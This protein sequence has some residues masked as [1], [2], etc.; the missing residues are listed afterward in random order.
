MVAP[1]VLE[2]LLSAYDAR[3]AWRLGLPAGDF[4][5]WIR[6]FQS[7]GGTS[8]PSESL[9]HDFVLKPI[10]TW[11][12]PILRNHD[13]IAGLGN[14][15]LIDFGKPAGHREVAPREFDVH[16]RWKPTREQKRKEEEEN[17]KKNKKNKKGRRRQSRKAEA[18]CVARFA[19]T[20]YWPYTK[21][22]HISTALQQ[23]SARYYVWAFGLTAD[24]CMEG[25]R[26]ERFPK[27]VDV[28][29]RWKPQRRRDEDRAV[30]QKQLE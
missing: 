29:A 28:H 14:I 15:Y 2:Q 5:F 23:S 10:E 24:R 20:A 27:E 8:K 12:F 22:V 3:E 26:G 6:G 21:L 30:D 7:H 11:G 16:S 1:K 25:D 4:L 9:D 18:A 13:F 19:V 17:N